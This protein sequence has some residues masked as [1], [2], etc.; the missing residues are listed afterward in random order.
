MRLIKYM[1]IAATLVFIIVFISNLSAQ[2]LSKTDTLIVA[3]AW[4]QSKMAEMSKDEKLGQLFMPRA[5]SQKNKKHTAS[6]K[7]LIRENKIGGLCF[8][9]GTPTEQARLINEYQ[10]ISDIPLMIAIDAEWGLGMRFKKDAISFPMQLELG[11]IQDEQLIFQMGKKIAEHCR[12]VGVTVNFAP[13]VD[14][15]NN[16]G[17]PVINDRSFGEDKYNVAAKGRAYMMGLEEGGVLSCAKHFP[18]HGDTDVDSHLDLPVITHDMDR[19]NDIELMPFRSLAKDIGSMMVAHVHM[20]AIDDR[21]NRPTTLSLNAVTGILKNEYNYKGLVMTD[22]LDMKGVTKHFEPGQS[23]AEALLAGNDVL[24]LSEDIPKA[25]ETIKEYIDKGKIKWSKVDASVEKILTFKYMLGLRQSPVIENIKNIDRDIHDA[26][27]LVLKEKL[28]ENAL[29][30]VKNQASLIPIART[31]NRKFASLAI[32]STTETPFQKRLSSFMDVAHHSISKNLSQA[33]IDSTLKKLSDYDVVFVSTH[34]MSKYE[35]KKFGLTKGQATLIQR[36]ATK[37][38]IVL[39]VFGSPYA[40]KPFENIPTI[41]MAYSEDPIN[42]DKAAQALMGVIDIKGKLPVSASKNITS[43]MGLFISSIG[44][45]GYADPER[46]GMSSDSL[47]YIEKIVKD[48]IAKKAAPGCQ[49]LCIKDGFVIFDEVYGYHTYDKK[50]KVQPTDLYDV[51]SVTKILASTIS[52]MKLED[53][54]RI[55]LN[56]PVVNYLPVLDTCNKKDL[57][58]EDMLA[59]H[60]G[61]RGWVPFYK[62]TLAPASYYKRKKNNKKRPKTWKPD[63]NYYRTTASDSFSILVSEDLYMRTDYV[64]SIY[65]RIYGTTL[66]ED[67]DYKYSDLGFY[68]VHQIIHRL[69]GQRLDQY[70]WVNFYRPMGLEHTL[71]NPLDRFTKEEITPSEKDNYFRNTSVHGYVHDMGAAMLG[72][73]AG[74]AGLFSTARDLA[75]LMQMLLN[76]GSYLGKEYIEA[77]TVKKYTTRHYRSQRRGIG[78]DMKQ[79]DPDEKLNMSAAAN[80]GTFGHLGFTGTSIFADPEENLVYVFLSNR[81]YPTMKNK[82]FGRKNYRPRIQ[83]VFYKA[84]GYD[85]QIDK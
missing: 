84:L 59:H 39:T 12:R 64:D 36:L 7:R 79:L 31:K 67:R 27:A 66:K 35:S 80:D 76:G 49:I 70:A 18:G 65:S 75:T 51:A 37:T 45:I 38:D 71:F 52:L 14:V 74:H 56:E 17:N 29:T 82:V 41:L 30:M 55:R 40:L 2:F 69:T 25:I 61:M 4:A 28:I 83:S 57:I 22:A 34:D 32:G 58:L 26:E 13:V 5:F 1:R 16:P 77:N 24:L 62:E 53:Q 6:I 20:P 68:L 78:F 3:K 33:D 19:I 11:A 72:G 85:V 21:K 10:K 81:T 48:M 44:R 46:V 15:N 23:E 47:K 73:V 50:I 43:G 54:G 9:Q 42:Q 8:F 60:A 63:K